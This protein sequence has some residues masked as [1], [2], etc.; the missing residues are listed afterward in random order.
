MKGSGPTLSKPKS[1]KT[2]KATSVPSLMPPIPEAPYVLPQP[3]E[4][5]EKFLELPTDI[6]STILTKGL[7]T[8]KLTPVQQL[9]FAATTLPSVV[10]SVEFLLP[11]KV[12]A[13]FQGRYNKTTEEKQFR[14]AREITEYI[15]QLYQKEL[16]N[17][18]DSI[19]LQ[20]NYVIVTI[21]N[22]PSTIDG[23]ITISS[24]IPNTEFPMA[25]F[26]LNFT[27][28]KNQSDSILLSKVLLT[29][30]LNNYLDF[31]N[32]KEMF[33]GL[34]WLSFV[35]NKINLQKSLLHFEDPNNI[36]VYLTDTMMVGDIKAMDKEF[37]QKAL[38]LLKYLEKSLASRQRTIR[39][40][41]TSTRRL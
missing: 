1:S 34:R 8:S 38:L 6:Q 4:N 28:I 7:A 9:Q 39:R 21:I 10:Q 3:E 22:K 20:N 35:F 24:V 31:E 16:T 17:G 23:S 41:T 13:I 19:K 5:F 15:S 32:L 27:R 36:K 2:K 30:Y 37:I 25:S 11:T 26:R 14:T 18:L 29:L 12:T 33:I 40:G